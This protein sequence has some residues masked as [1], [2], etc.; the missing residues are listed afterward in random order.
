MTV[1]QAR[2]LACPVPVPSSESRSL[3]FL[4]AADSGSLRASYTYLV[5][6]SLASL[7]NAAAGVL[8]PLYAI[9]ARDLQAN[10]AM[11]GLVTAVYVLIAAASAAYWGY[12]GDRSNRQRLLLG[13]TL[14]WGSAMIATG[15]ARTFPQ[16]I[17]CQIVTAVGVGSIASIGFSVISDVI[18]AR[19]RGLALSLWGISQS[20]GAAVG[21]LLAGMLGAFDWR[22]PFWFI[23]GLG[24][25][26]AFLYF[27]T[28]EPQRGQSEPELQALFA[29]GKTYD[30]RITRTDLPVIFARRSNIW[31]SV[32]LIFATLA[33]GSTIWVPRWAIARV[34]AL[35]YSLEVSTIVG[36]LFVIL[37]SAGIF[38]GIAA[39]YVG[40]R[41]QQRDPQGR[42]KLAMWGAFGSIPFFMLTFFMPISGVSLPPGASVWRLSWSVFVLL[43][44]NRSVFALFL[45][46]FLAIGLL[47]VDAPNWAALITEANLPEHRGTVI[48]LTR[49]VRAI[50]NA[51]S[52]ALT[53]LLLQLLTQQFPPPDN[54]AWGLAL[55]QLFAIPA[56]LCYYG[57]RKTIPAD[58][59]AVRHTLQQRAATAV[60]P[61]K[62]IKPE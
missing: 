33:F 10:E 35:G 15:L 27:F 5:F 8:P 50:S 30:Y 51:V 24:F 36:N 3:R 23:A 52:I 25:L 4:S 61:L 47:A 28:E 26:F 34:Q 29:A 14:L 37:F 45:T 20:L 38:M 19:R 43:L 55:F 31:L 62:G 11:L 54:Y 53:G 22:W 49:I 46:A 40:D 42:L 18:P 9:I 2:L 48:G 59:D 21:V 58:I 56:G 13:G 1:P 7:D 44:T 32:Q 17:L 60:Q 57:A 12:R 6:V 16:F 39:G 41:W